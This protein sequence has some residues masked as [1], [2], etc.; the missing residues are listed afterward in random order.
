MSLPAPEG[1]PIVFLDRDGTISADRG[2]T[3]LPGDMR[4]FTGSG[5]AIARLKQ[6]GYRAVIV[7]NQ[8]AIGRGYATREAVEATNEECRRQLREEHRDAVIDWVALCPHRPDEACGCR[9]PL[10]GMIKNS[11]FPWA[12]DARR[13]WMVGDKIIDL[14]FGLALGL[15]PA[16]CVLV[17]TGEGEHERLSSARPAGSV[18]VANL[19]DASAHILKSELNSL[20]A[21]ERD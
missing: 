1:E 16:H 10:P 2:Y 18:V 17:C 11:A 13:S 15:A 19:S 12:F 14:E 6:A 4:I 5:T 7:T 3:V 9:K 8:S 21:S 20:A